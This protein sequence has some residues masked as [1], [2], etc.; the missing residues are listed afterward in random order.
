MSFLLS[1][2]DP[3]Q[4]NRDFLEGKEDFLDPISVTQPPEFTS[5]YTFRN[6][7]YI[8]QAPYRSKESIRCIWCNQ[9]GPYSQGVGLPIKAEYQE[10]EKVK[11]YQV[12]GY[13]CSYEC[14]LAFAQILQFRDPRYR[15]TIRYLHNM[16]RQDYPGEILYPAND[17]WLRQEYGGPLKDRDWRKSRYIPTPNRL[18]IPVAREYRLEI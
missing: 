16:F 2:I 9:V 14:G 7:D 3:Y 12:E 18:V 15:D 1:G 5:I 8:Y 13:S 4:I 17:Y 6:R 10:E 11:I